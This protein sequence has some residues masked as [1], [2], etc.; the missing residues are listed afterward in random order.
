MDTAKRPEIRRSI[1]VVSLH[2]RRNN[3]DRRKRKRR[4][5]KKRTQR[6]ARSKKPA[7]DDRRHERKLGNG[8]RKANGGSYIRLNEAHRRS[9]HIGC[10]GNFERP[11]N[12][13]C[14]RSLWYWV[15]NGGSGQ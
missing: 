11:K 13:R 2:K 6:Q 1:E 8:G 10:S 7:A 3:G 9:V 4:R 12:H 15:D 5:N 14:R